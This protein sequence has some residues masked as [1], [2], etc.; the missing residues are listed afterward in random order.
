MD[1][2]GSTQLLNR[3][4]SALT[5]FVVLEIFPQQ[6]TGEN[7]SIPIAQHFYGGIKHEMDQG[8]I[9]GPGFV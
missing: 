6:Q 2:H 5:L 3:G 9:F 7:R 4:W 8:A 1:F